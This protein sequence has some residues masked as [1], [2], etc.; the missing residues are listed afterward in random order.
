MDNGLNCM[1]IGIKSGHKYLIMIVIKMEKKMVNGILM[2]I[3]MEQI[4]I[5]GNF[6]EELKMEY[7]QMC[8]MIGVQ[9][10]DKSFIMVSIRWAKKL[11]HGK[12]QRTQINKCKNLE[13]HKFQS[14][15]GDYNEYGMKNSKW[16]EP[17]E[18]WDKKNLKFI[19]EG[20]YK[21]GLK[22]GQWNRIDNLNGINNSLF[23]NYSDDRFLI[24]NEL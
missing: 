13:Y 18:K 2:I 24:E 19:Y 9:V 4:N 6:K 23:E 1:I 21:N 10:G 3:I 7:G 17:D 16:F 14:G 8:M 20:E 5:M 12:S 11:E 15:G 22:I